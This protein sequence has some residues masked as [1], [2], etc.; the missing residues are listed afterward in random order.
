MAVSLTELFDR[1][2]AHW[3]DGDLSRVIRS[4][5]Y[6]KRNHA[7]R[8]AAHAK[9]RAHLEA[10]TG[11]VHVRAHTRDAGRVQVASYNRVAPPGS[12]EEAAA[13]QLELDKLE[14]QYR[15]LAANWRGRDRKRAATHLEHFLDGSGRPIEYSRKEA[16]Q[17]KQ[18]ASAAESARRDLER[19]MREEIARQVVNLGAG[20]A[21][22]V[23]ME[24]KGEGKVTMLPYGFS[25]V[26]GALTRD[27]DDELAV[28]RT[29]VRA[30]FEGRVRRSTGIEVEGTVTYV[31][32]DHYDFHPGQPGARDLLRLQ[33]WRGAKPFAMQATW[34]Q[35]VIGST[36]DS[37]HV[38]GIVLNHADLNP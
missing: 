20:S 30:F 33:Q 16:L 6:Q 38:A 5:A 25:A 21:S 17:F 18:V 12:P 13:Q 28:G 27:L 7:G 22:S 32:N 10:K 35:R 29:T 4:D 37:A 23:S 3:S 14:Q 9:V 34:R 2:P 8:Q 31:W 11:R 15:S 36:E 26:V 19:S 1:D 24:A